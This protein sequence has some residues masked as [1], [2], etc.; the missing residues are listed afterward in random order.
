M[1]SKKTPEVPPVQLPGD[2]DALLGDDYGEEEVKGPYNTMEKKLER[3][4]EYKK[5]ECS[6]ITL[7]ESFSNVSAAKKEDSSAINS[8][9]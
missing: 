2:D 5:Q 9:N 7:D 1:S 4:E 6:R 8:V 3:L